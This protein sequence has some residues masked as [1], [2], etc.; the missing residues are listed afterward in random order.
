M[1]FAVAQVVGD[2]VL[3]F[4]VSFLA[5]ECCN[6]IDESVCLSLRRLNT[7]MYLRNLG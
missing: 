5:T 2:H 6:V 1:T 7:E 3:F 4:F